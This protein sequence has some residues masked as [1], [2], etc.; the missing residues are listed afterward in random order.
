MFVVTAWPIA[1][2]CRVQ[3]EEN[4]LISVVDDAAKGAITYTDLASR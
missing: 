2:D 1:V 3:E 4:L